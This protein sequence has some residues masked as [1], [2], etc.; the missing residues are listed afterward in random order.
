VAA[1]LDHYGIRVA[2]VERSVHFYVNALGA[3]QMTRPF[4]I[5]GEFAETIMEGP[6]GVR[7]LLCHLRLARG[8]LELFQFLEPVHAAE[9]AHP[10]LGNTL[11]VALHVDDVDDT[12][13]RI[14]DAGGSI[15]FPVKTW[16]RH[17]LTYTK[18]PD[19]NV[20][21]VSDAPL[22]ELL[23]GTLAQFPEAR[24]SH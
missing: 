6:P 19:G 22:E 18:D 13:A 10:T 8:M 16:G 7:F 17:R 12:V 9:P 1:R 4:V 21:E 23:A 3:E 24:L 5:E 2:D 11:H 14:V 15:V 20:I